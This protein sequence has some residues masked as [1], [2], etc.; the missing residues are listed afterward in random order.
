MNCPVCAFDNDLKTKEELLEHITF[1]HKDN[2]T[3]LIQKFVEY[4][5]DHET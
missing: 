1:Q 4:V 2:P 5:A 3:L